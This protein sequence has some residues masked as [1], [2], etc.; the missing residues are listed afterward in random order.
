MLMSGI[1]GW[2][3]VEGRQGMGFW[4]PVMLGVG[5]LG[6]VWV[7]L[8]GMMRTGSPSAIDGLSPGSLVAVY[9]VGSGLAGVIIGALNPFVRSRSMSAGVG[10]L[11]SLPPATL[12]AMMARPGG[13]MGLYVLSG[14]ITSLMLGAGYGAIFYEG[15]E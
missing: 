6:S 8:A 3:R 10:F 11:A 12:V 14:V 9:L 1:G 15:E 4:V 2:R 13:P 5:V 7:V